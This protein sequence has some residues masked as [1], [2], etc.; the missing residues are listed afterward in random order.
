MRTDES[1]YDASVAAAISTSCACFIR[2][3]VSRSL[4]ACH[5]SSPPSSSKSMYSSDH[6]SSRRPS[7]SP[8][9]ECFD[10]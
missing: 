9:C 2:S 6:R 4:S 7:S 1:T 3:T 8:R 10:A 5:G